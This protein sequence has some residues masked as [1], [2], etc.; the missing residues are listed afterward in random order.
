MRCTPKLKRW[1]R[2]RPQ[3]PADGVGF[4]SLRRGSVWMDQA[5]GHRAK[6]RYADVRCA[7]LQVRKKLF[8]RRLGNGEVVT[9]DAVKY[10]DQPRALCLGLFDD[11]DELGSRAGEEIRGDVIDIDIRGGGLIH[12]PARGDEPRLNEGHVALVRVA[13]PMDAAGIGERERRRLSERPELGDVGIELGAHP[14]SVVVLAG[15]PG[16][17]PGI[18]GR[19]GMTK[20]V[21]RELVPLGVKLS[22]GI[23]V[24]RRIRDEK[25]GP[26]P[27][28]SQRGC[29]DVDF[30]SRECRRT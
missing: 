13:H 30:D 5:R 25:R 17:D 24:L 19:T 27:M 11:L 26:E 1:G 6:G 15:I 8:V 23:G 14:A 9:A 18:G 16:F 29:G 22:P 4:M 10:E 3:T 7:R 12:D 28:L 20:G 21:G 2:E